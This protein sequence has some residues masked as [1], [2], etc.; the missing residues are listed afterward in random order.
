M[1]SLLILIICAFFSVNALASGDSC[2]Q[3]KQELK[4]MHKAQKAMMGS[5]VNNHESFASTLEEYAVTVKQDTASKSN[6]TTQ[7]G[8]SAQAFRH[9]GFQGKKMATQLDKATA[10]LIERVSACL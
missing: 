10:D 6:I 2:A 8:K 1:K 3:L 4:G 5:L 9:R 7:M